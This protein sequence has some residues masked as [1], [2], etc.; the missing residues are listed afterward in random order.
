MAVDLA[1]GKD[2]MKKLILILA[3]S[4][5]AATAGIAKDSDTISVRLGHSKAIDGGKITIKFL[6]IVEDSRC[7]MNARCI[8]AGNAKIRL[9]MTKGRSFRSVELNTGTGVKTVTAYGYTFEI[10]DLTPWPGAPPEMASEPK[11][12]KLSIVKAR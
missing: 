1:A 5:L 11:I 4:I 7:P 12:V 8:W 3:I 9:S 6:K 10:E 2:D